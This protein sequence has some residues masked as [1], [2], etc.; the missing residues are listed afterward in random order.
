MGGDPTNL[1]LDQTKQL[2]S[3]QESKRDAVKEPNPMETKETK[4]QDD[5]TETSCKSTL[6]ADTDK[7]YGEDK[8]DKDK[9]N[10]LPETKTKDATKTN[11][12]KENTKD[13]FDWLDDK[14]CVFLLA[15]M[16]TIFM[17]WCFIW[18]V[19]H[20][21]P[22]LC[23]VFI[24]SNARPLESVF[25]CFDRNKGWT[26]KNI[27]N[28]A[29]IQMIF[30]EIL[31]TWNPGTWS[32][33]PRNLDELQHHRDLEKDYQWLAISTYV[34][35][36]WIKRSPPSMLAIDFVNEMFK[37]CPVC[38]IP[39]PCPTHC[40]VCTVGTSTS[41][42]QLSTPEQYCHPCNRCNNSYTIDT[43]QELTEVCDK[44]SSLIPSLTSQSQTQTQTLIQ[45]PSSPPLTAILMDKRIS[46]TDVYM[47]Q[48]ESLK[49]SNAYFYP[50]NVYL[51]TEA[52]KES[53]HRAIKVGTTMQ[54]GFGIFSDDHGFLMIMQK[55]CN[56]VIYKYF[57]EQ[58][59]SNHAVW[60]THT[61]G[62]SDHCEFRVFPNGMQLWDFK[63]QNILWQKM[64]TPPELNNITCV[65]VTG[66]GPDASNYC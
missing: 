40:P 13:W 26:P 25:G 47:F 6:T 3:S 44:L 54:Q 10:S 48:K 45:S 15:L 38:P 61:D 5:S 9:S 62:K 7:T 17:T 59:S 60:S 1:P 28:Y 31:Q 39:E 8:K 57:N 20:T 27:H 53:K 43:I 30:Q 14:L 66:Y 63:H 51:Y 56:L 52:A 64:R 19:I 4:E 2:N 33:I 11:T 24:G 18:L 65:R 46:K 41:K 50:V 29:E 55:D 34:K 42:G 12:N 22:K 35:E 16:A 49:A 32:G 58:A 36:K 21:N 37:C 23:Q